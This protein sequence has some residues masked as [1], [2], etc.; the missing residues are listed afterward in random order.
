MCFAFA[1]HDGS[2]RLRLAAAIEPRSPEDQEKRVRM[3][4]RETAKVGGFWWGILLVD[5]AGLSDETGTLRR[6]V[7]G[8]PLL[9]LLARANQKWFKPSKVTKQLTE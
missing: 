5:N 8:K 1:H 4:K 3:E 6:D 2:T 7:D 9:N